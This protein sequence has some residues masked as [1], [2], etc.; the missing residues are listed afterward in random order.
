MHVDYIK[1]NPIPADKHFDVLDDAGNLVARA[2]LNHGPSATDGKWW[3]YEPFGDPI[4][5]EMQITGKFVEREEAEAHAN[6]AKICPN[7]RRAWQPAKNA[8]GNGWKDKREVQDRYE[9]K[10]G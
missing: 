5:G 8:S 9:Y 2:I 6:K 1:Q 10:A 7:K 3:V 4:L